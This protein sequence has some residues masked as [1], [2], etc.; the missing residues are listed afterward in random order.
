MFKSQNIENWGMFLWNRNY[1]AS[2]TITVNSN[3]NVI[4]WYTH[5][6]FI[7]AAIY[8]VKFSEEKGQIA[9]SSFWYINNPVKE[10]KDTQKEI[11]QHV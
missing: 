6:L 5:R 7:Q 3:C 11:L 8:T 2:F 1:G 10:A 4:Y 9:V